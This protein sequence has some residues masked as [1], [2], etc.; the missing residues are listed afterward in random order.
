M[1]MLFVAGCSANEGSW[2]PLA[3]DPPASE[4]TLLP[5][6]AMP[7]PSPFSQNQS[8][9]EA[10]AVLAELPT[11][12]EALL[13]DAAKNRR[14][15]EEAKQAL[16]IEENTQLQGM[17]YRTAQLALS[18]LSQVE[19]RLS[20]LWRTTDTARVTLYAGQNNSDDVPSQNLESSLQRLEQ[21]VAGLNSYLKEERQALIQPSTAEN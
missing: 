14:Q 10:K 6:V 3:G 4:V 7:P 18:R 15:Y 8:P 11:R 2:P 13:E 20:A 16:T 12:L 5:A 19:S 1:A 21:A 9:L 17:S